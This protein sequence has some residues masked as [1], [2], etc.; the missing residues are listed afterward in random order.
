MN[1]KV[2]GKIEKP[3]EINPLDVIRK[4]KLQLLGRDD[5]FVKNG[6][7]QRKKYYFNSEQTYLDVASNEI[8]K[9]ID[10]V[11]ALNLIEKEL[12]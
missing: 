12:S 10:L 1:I 7:V 11:K 5:Y 3:I 4:L 8:Q 2:T 9:K 6:K